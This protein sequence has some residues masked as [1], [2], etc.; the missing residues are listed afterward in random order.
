MTKFL[1][2]IWTKR[3][4][5]VFCSLYCMLVV[6]F[7]AMS[8]SYDFY[9]PNKTLFVVLYIGI[10][11]F[12]TALMLF[13]RR[14]LL[15]RIYSFVMLIAFLPT[16]LFNFGNWAL[17]IPMALSIL[18]LFFASGAGEALKTVLGTIILL[19]YILSTIGFFL[20]TSVMTPS[21]NQVFIEEKVSPSGTYRYKSYMLTSTLK[22]GA[23][24]YVEPNLLDKDMKFIKFISKD[25]ENLVYYNT[26]GTSCDVEWQGDNIY[27]K[28]DPNDQGP[29]FDAKRD[30]IF[31]RKFLVFDMY[32]Y[33][34]ITGEKLTMEEVGI[35]ST[36]NKP[37]VT[38]P[39]YTNVTTPPQ[40][41]AD[42]VDSE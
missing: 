19:V 33:N 22:G 3:G 12:F 17:I 41:E 29:W 40:T 11:L 14:Q 21:G 9:I 5:S 38:E 4:I 31:I 27:V 39:E 25:M 36:K 16:F 6:Y 7:G 37:A 35:I 32:G 28:S 20:Y 8:F 34:A 15:I 30:S 18:I 1:T 26:A 24:V 42:V 2:N 23:R 10:S 13:T